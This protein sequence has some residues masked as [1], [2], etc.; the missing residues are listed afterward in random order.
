M[1]GII[2][3][4]DYLSYHLQPDK[5]L[6]SNEYFMC[7]KILINAIDVWPYNLHTN[8]ILVLRGVIIY[9]LVL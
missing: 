2:I 3:I 7:R 8:V 9:L 4:L 6:I 5:Y 1:G